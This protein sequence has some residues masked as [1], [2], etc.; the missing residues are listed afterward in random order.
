[1]SKHN[2]PIELSDGEKLIIAMIADLSRAPS[3]RDYDAEFIA[4]SVREGHSWKIRWKYDGILGYDEADPDKV[5]QVSK[6]FQMWS[7]V[8]R[9]VAAWSPT[10]RAAYE[11]L[12]ED[13]NKDPKYHGYD[14]NNEDE[15]GIARE[16]VEELKQF[17]EF[18]GR[19]H[20]SHMACV[21]KYTR[22]EAVFSSIPSNVRY[23]NLSPDQIAA[24]VNA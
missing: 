11:A 9:S 7:V 15:Y 20:N 6:N 18:S 8:E 21:E 4:Q 3:D 5:S 1:M 13:Y 17:N 23:K 24:I 10:E 14:G 19:D 16:M 12:V 22:M 2:K